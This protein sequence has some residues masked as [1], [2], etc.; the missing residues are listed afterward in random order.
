V[1]ILSLGVCS[2]NILRP[3]NATSHNMRTFE[4]P[5]TANAMVTARSEEQS[6]FF[7]EGEEMECFDT[8]ESLLAKIQM[9]S[10]DRKHSGMIA[11]NGYE[12]VRE[13]TYA[14]RART[15]ISLLG[16]A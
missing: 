5:A 13:E 6:E 11:Q 14:K 15:M 2:I 8:P 7:A 10:K 4:I 9:L 3:Q 1:R 16:F 12:R